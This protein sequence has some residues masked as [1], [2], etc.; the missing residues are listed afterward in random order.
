V[1]FD[2]EI[3]VPLISVP[4]ARAAELPRPPAP[5]PGVERPR[6][7]P[8]TQ[9]RPAPAPTMSKEEIDALYRDGTRLFSA[10]D[11]QAAM[12]IWQ[13]ILKADPGHANARRNMERTRQKLEALKKT[14]G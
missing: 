3:T 11:Y 1:V 12:K 6:P 4:E 10:G 7:T 8:P 2:G 13:R 5:K 9:P 14:R